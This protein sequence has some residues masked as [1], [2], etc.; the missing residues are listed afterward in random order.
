[1]AEN[2]NA[3]FYVTCATVI[4]VLFL[5]AAVQGQAFVFVLQRARR[6]TGRQRE[7][8]TLRFLSPKLRPGG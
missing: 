4:P 2:F 5:A 6:R 8:A 1:M 7:R 3:N